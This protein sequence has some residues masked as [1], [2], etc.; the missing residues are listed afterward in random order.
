MTFE[1]GARPQREERCASV[2]AAGDQARRGPP[3]LGKRGREHV[4]RRASREQLH[5]EERGGSLAELL[6]VELRQRVDMTVRRE[7]DEVRIVAVGQEQAVAR[8]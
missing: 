5:V 3:R 6:E 4:D 8:N 2:A 7:H 1:V